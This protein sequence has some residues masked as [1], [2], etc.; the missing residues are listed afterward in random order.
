MHAKLEH[1]GRTYTANLDKPLDLSMPLDTNP[2]RT[3][4]WGVAPPAF[5][6][7]RMGDWVGAVKAGAPVNFFNVHFNPHGNGTHTESVGHI[8]PE[9]HPV[10]QLVKK[11]FFLAEVIT[12]QPEPVGPD[13]V[14]TLSSLQKA[15]KDLSVEA[16]AIRH[17]PNSSNKLTTAYT[18]TNPTYMSQ[19]AAAFIRQA[20]VEHLLI[21]LPSVDR[22]EDGGALAA[23]H[24]FWDYPNAPR[25]NATISELIFVPD[26]IKDGKYLL[27]LQ[28]APFELDAAPSR[29][30]LFAL[31]EKR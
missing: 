27:N 17:L 18:G 19:E 30:V 2:N 10:N 8:A 31:E 12:V 13:H 16:L 20:G 21:D 4:A 25:Y 7:V 11:F 28:I 22:E 1:L 9:Q 5:E 23:H 3:S 14:I 26:H 6:P 29:P 15:W 24:A